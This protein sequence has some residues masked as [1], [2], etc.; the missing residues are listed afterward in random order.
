MYSI[1]DVAW[2]RVALDHLQSFLLD[3]GEEG[4][5]WEAKSD[6]PG[7]TEEHGQRLTAR[8]VRRSV[9]GLANQ[10]GG[11]L[12]IGARY[13]RGAWWLRGIVKPG[14][15]PEL[16]LDQVLRG[17][18]PAPR[19]DRKFWELEDGRV[20]GVVRVEPLSQTPCMTS[21]G[22]VFERT[23]SETAQVKDP[24]RLNELFR[25]GE[26]ARERAEAQAAA[27]ATELLEHPDV[28]AN[29]SVWVGLG[30]VAGSYEEDIGARLFHSR[31]WEAARAG[32]VERLWTESGLG[33]VREPWDEIRQDYVELSRGNKECHW[34]LRAHWSGRVAVL[35]AL[36]GDVVLHGSLFD[37]VVLPAW[38][39]AAD[40]VKELGGYGDARAQL[41]V[42]VQTAQE[43]AQRPIGDGRPGPA[44]PKGNIYATLPRYTHIQRT[45]EVREPTGEEIGSIQRELQRAAGLRTFEGQPDPP[46]A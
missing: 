31:F 22:Q 17:L 14:P 10:V 39:L 37:F 24:A 11:Y 23:S 15:E 1:F 3:A 35:A 34:I 30:L 44:P 32:Y 42:R 2:D 7:A 25:R 19:W 13:S 29:R 6:Q 27:A 20:A 36:A 5:T 45:A 40:L 9:C 28:R 38:R 41:S 26:A 16:W 21:D 18:R 33:A 12:I 43:A 46:E 4:V 8:D